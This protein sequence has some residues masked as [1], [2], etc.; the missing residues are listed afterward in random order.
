MK[1][2]YCNDV[3]CL[4]TQV[5]SD[6]RDVCQRSVTV[7]LKPLPPNAFTNVESGSG[8]GWASGANK[9]VVIL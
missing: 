5:Q 2:T 1:K 4:H 8:S 7:E 3:S 6:G 9:V